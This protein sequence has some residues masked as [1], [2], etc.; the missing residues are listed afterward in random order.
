MFCDEFYWPTIPPA[1]KNARA[2]HKKKTVLCARFWNCPPLYKSTSI[3]CQVTG[4]WYELIACSCNAVSAPQL[5]LDGTFEPF[6]RGKVMRCISR[7]ATSS[8]CSSTLLCLLRRGRSRPCSPRV[9]AGFVAVVVFLSKIRCFFLPDPL[10]HIIT[11]TL[12]Q[13]P[14]PPQGASRGQYVMYIGYCPARVWP[15]YP[16]QPDVSPHLKPERR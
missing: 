11:A 12:L 4:T 9:P 15:C 2:I 14:I 7:P 10:A 13:T 5:F 1:K 3:I 16:T 8:S 6:S